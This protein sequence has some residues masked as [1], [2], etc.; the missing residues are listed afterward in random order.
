[1]S[2]KNMSL[3]AKILSS[4]EEKQLSG[5]AVSTADAGKD[6]YL[7]ISYQWAAQIAANT[8]I[9]H[10]F[11][12]SG[13]QLYLRSAIKSFQK[14]VS[15][16]FTRGAGPDHALMKPIVPTESHGQNCLVESR[17]LEWIQTEKKF[18]KYI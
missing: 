13:I 16:H 7:C 5:P 15:G 3:R 8:Y 6:S 11:A 18:K 14:V 2:H 17:N 10:I 1:M 4:W 9:L 12:D